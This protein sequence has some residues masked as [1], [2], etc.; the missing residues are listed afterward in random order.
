MALTLVFWTAVLMTG[1]VGGL[2]A[3]G[4]RLMTPI[5]EET[6]G[7][8]VPGRVVRLLRYGTTGGGT[9]ATVGF[10]LLATGE[11]LRIGEL[12][13]LGIGGV[14]LG[15]PVFSVAFGAS[16]ALV[17]RVRVVARGEERPRRSRVE[18]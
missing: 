2:T 1:I 14:V 8:R 15:G 16:I 18:K 5:F 4:P 12:G 11:A 7:V 17:L 3:L 10:L 13:L 6:D 9:V